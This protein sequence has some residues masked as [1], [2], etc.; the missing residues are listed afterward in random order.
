MPTGGFRVQR[1]ARVEVKTEAPPPHG[2]YQ[3][4]RMGVAP[5]TEKPAVTTAYAKK[6]A[7]RKAREKA[8]EE[9]RDQPSLATMIRR[10]GRTG[11]KKKVGKKPSR[12]G[13]QRKRP[14]GKGQ[15]TWKRCE[16]GWR[17]WRHWRRNRGRRRRQAPQSP[18]MS[19]TTTRMTMASATN[20]PI[21]PQITCALI[22]STATQ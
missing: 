13:T 7:E 22:R 4:G 5:D 20:R 3:R 19:G 9:E 10:A 16:E 21:M 11:V 2:A 1:A 12:R 8:R 17:R 15:K 18:G 14:L 6:V